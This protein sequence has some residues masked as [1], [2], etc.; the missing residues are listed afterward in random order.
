MISTAIYKLD[1][2][3]VQWDVAHLFEHLLIHAWHTHLIVNNLNSSLYG[4]V[5]GA[6]FEQY[7]FLD[8]GFYD[9]RTAELFDDFVHSSLRFSAIEIEKS[10]ADIGAEEKSEFSITD[11]QRLHQEIIHLSDRLSSHKTVADITQKPGSCLKSKKASKRYRDVTLLIRAHGL[12]DN[13][14]VAF[15]RL[16]VIL[17]D[18]ISRSLKDKYVCYEQGNSALTRNDQDMGYISK[19][20]LGVG[21]GT[22]SELATYLMLTIKQFQ[23]ERDW[24]QIELHLKTYADEALWKSISIE[25]YRETGIAASPDEVA[26]LTTKRTI[27]SIFSKITI[28]ATPHNSVNDKWIQ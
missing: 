8:T 1:V 5:R 25:Y 9:K 16:K 26:E 28:E 6:T 27:Q 22:L 2:H 3:D 10:L 17:I 21:Q 23:V 11:T 15:L 4:W 20:T 12:N 7:I 18:I 13:E 24:S 19:L 14:Q